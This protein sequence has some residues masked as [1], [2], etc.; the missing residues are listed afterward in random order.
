MAFS[1]ILVAMLRL[2]NGST[3][4]QELPFRRL[5]KRSVHLFSQHV[6]SALPAKV[7]AE[8]PVP[9]IGSKYHPYMKASRM[10]GNRSLE[11]S[12][13]NKF[14]VRGG[15][16]VSA[17][18]ETLLSDLGIVKQRTAFAN[19]TCTEFVARS[20][21]MTAEYMKKVVEQQSMKTINA[22]FDTARI[23]HEDVS[24]IRYCIKPPKRDRDL[25]SRPTPSSA[26]TA[27]NPKPKTPGAQRSKITRAAPPVKK[28]ELMVPKIFLTA[29]WHPQ[30]PRCFQLYCAWTAGNL[31]VR[32]SLCPPAHATPGRPR[33]QQRPW[34]V[35][36]ETNCPRLGVHASM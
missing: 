24:R 18:T 14:L 3:F 32:P 28:Q 34:R 23:C 29:Q 7:L 2:K 4:W 8:C 5:V 22:C 11:Q 1:A 30:V 10:K 21:S 17:K 36:L 25:D 12:L 6:E 20:L 35:Q 27:L 15:G 13:V 33:T 16:F 31:P 9:D 19:R 26:S